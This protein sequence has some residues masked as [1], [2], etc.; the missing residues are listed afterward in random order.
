MKDKWIN[1][2]YD[3]ED[4]KPHT[5]PVEDLNN[6]SRIGEKHGPFYYSFVLYDHSSQENKLLR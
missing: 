6:I 2:G 4:L 3:G 5:E 1:I